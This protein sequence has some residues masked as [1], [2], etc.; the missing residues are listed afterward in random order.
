MVEAHEVIAHL[1]DLP[2]KAPVNGMLRG[3]LHN[4]VP[5]PENAKLIEIDPLNDK[6]VCGVIRDKWRAV[7]GGV[8][9]AIMLKCNTPAN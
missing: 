4:G 8:L 9:E 5:A 2:L 3:L 1:G 7:A 6:A